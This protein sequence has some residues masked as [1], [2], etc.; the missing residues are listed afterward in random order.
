MRVTLNGKPDEIDEGATVADL[1]A[2]LKLEPIRVAVEINEDIVPRKTF[3][4]KRIQDGDRIEVVTF[5]GGG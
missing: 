1:L 3:S 2:R 4:N 5:V